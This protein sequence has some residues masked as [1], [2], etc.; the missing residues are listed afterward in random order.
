MQVINTA[1][2]RTA[3]KGKDRYTALA[4]ARSLSQEEKK[5]LFPEFVF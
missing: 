5:A 2:V 4:V 3:I 1:I